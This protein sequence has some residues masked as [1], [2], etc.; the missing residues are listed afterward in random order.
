[1][2]SVIAH[3]VEIKGDII[4]QGSLRIDGGVDGKLNIKGDVILGE[5]GRIKGEV[6]VDNLIVAG[7][8]EGNVVASGRFEITANG[9]FKGEVTCSIL[10]IEEGGILDG[11]SR[12]VGQVTKPDFEARQTAKRQQENKTY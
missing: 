10:T 11:S 9:Y 7:R 5:K 1:M 4:S 12:M 2:E 6:K 3:G 8:V